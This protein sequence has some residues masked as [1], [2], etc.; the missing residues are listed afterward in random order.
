LLHYLTAKSGCYFSGIKYGWGFR[1]SDA[2]RVLVY[3]LSRSGYFNV[4]LVFGKKALAVIED[5]K[6]ANC[7]KQE[8]SN[9]KAF[10]EGTGIW[11]NVTDSSLVSNI[12]LLTTFKFAN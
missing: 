10:A 6:V 2:T 12:L 8:L 5:S 1:I 7:I 9:T 3:F 4:G 11:L